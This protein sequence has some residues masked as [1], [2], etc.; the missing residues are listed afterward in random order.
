MLGRSISVGKV[1]LGGSTHNN[2]LRNIQN[3]G[4]VLRAFLLSSLTLLAALFAFSSQLGY[5]EDVIF[6]VPGSSDP[7]S[8]LRFDP[9]LQIIEKGQSI[10]FVNPDGLDHHLVVKSADNKEEFDTGILSRNKFISHTFP[11]NGEYSFEC[12]IYPHMRG[13]IR[14]TDDIATFT[15]TIDN[16]N[17]D[18]QLARNP[19]NP[20]VNEE[21]YYKITFIDKETGRN[22]PHIDFTLTFND[23]SENYFDGTGGHTVDGQEY[24]VFYF[25]KED[26]FT[27][28]VTV[29][30]VNFI[31]INP[32]TVTFDTVVT[33]EFPPLG[34]AAV[35]I[36]ALGAIALY[37]RKK[38]S[39]T[40]L[41]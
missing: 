12:K 18:V 3:N 22:H 8:V 21:I 30:G 32:V 5:G 34:V 6:I 38:V 9:P 13:E 15:K 2:D 35:M 11:D 20:G 4:G 10:V 19:A 16:Q 40:Q 23:S 36:S 31:P 1:F 37:I 27:P 24:A 14:V 39:N 28:A 41:A 26:T 17:M 7:A 29:S 25:D 33:P